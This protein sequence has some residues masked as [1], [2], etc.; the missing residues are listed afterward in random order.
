MPKKAKKSKKIAVQSDSDDDDAFKKPKKKGLKIAISDSSDDDDGL[1]PSKGKIEIHIY[2][3]S[4]CCQNP[5]LL[6]ANAISRIFWS[7]NVILIYV[8]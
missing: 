1:C 7:G 4:K 6:I 3:R 8:C 2:F 5:L